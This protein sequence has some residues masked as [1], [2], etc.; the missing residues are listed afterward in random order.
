MTSLPTPDRNGG[1][2]MKS[3][4]YGCLVGIE[5]DKDKCKE[6]HPNGCDDCD[7]YLT[8]P[9][10]GDFPEKGDRSPDDPF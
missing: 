6:L 9:E 10:P 8:D 3:C 1:N 5:P 7:W 4:Y 2:R